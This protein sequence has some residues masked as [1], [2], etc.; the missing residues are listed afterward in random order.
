MSRYSRTFFNFFK[1]QEYQINTPLGCA[2]TQSEAHW[3]INKDWD[4]VF[5]SL[6]P[7]SAVGEKGKK[8]GQIGKHPL[9][10]QDYLS[11]L[12]FFAPTPI[13]SPFSPYA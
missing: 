1:A 4:E 2:S 10:S 13:F 5:V 3:V 9:P 6:R 11:A 12:F 7:G 8:Q